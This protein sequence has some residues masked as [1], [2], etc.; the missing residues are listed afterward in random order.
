M[1]LLYGVCS[2]ATLKSEEP[3]ALFIIEYISVRSSHAP[4]LGFY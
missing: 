1:L 4:G 3:E 2:A